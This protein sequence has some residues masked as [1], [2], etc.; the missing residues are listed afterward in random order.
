VDVVVNVEAGGPFQL[1]G[2]IAGRRTTLSSAD[3][4][5]NHRAFVADAS[6]T[7]EGLRQ[8]GA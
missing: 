2:L 1:I 8:A 3:D 6:F 7:C 5:G 4:D